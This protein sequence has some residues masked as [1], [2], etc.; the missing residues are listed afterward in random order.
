MYDVIVVGAGHAG[1][2]AA[3]AAAN[4][5]L[6]TLLATGNLNMTASMPCNPSIGGPAKGVVV[7]EIDALGGYMGKNADLCQIQTKM[8]NRSKGPAVWALRFQCD[9]LLYAREMLKH[10]KTV[11]NLDLVE[12][13]VEDVLVEDGSVKGITLDNGESIYSKAVILTTGTYLDSR[14]LRGH[15]TSKEG[16]DGQKT[17]KG[18]SN[19]LRR[20][21]FTIQRL[22]TGTPARIKASTID[23]S[24]VSVEN[25]DEITW[26][27]SHDKGYESL[28]GVKAPCYL[29]YT[30]QEIHDL[31]R[32]NLDK[33]AM[34]GGVVEGIGPRYCPSIEDKVVRFSDK[35]RHQIF[36]EPESLEIDQEYIQGF[37]TS[38]PVDVQDKMIRLLPGLKDCE[39]IRYAYA[40]EYDAIDPLE[41]WPSLE[42]KL[43]KN[44]FTAGQ[45]NGTS[46]YEEAAGQG[47][48]AG[49]NA[50]LK[51]QGKEPLILGR[52][53]AYIGLMIDDLV[54]K[55]TKEP[56]RLLTS[57]SEFRLLLRHD[58][59]DLRL[60]EK[61]YQVGLISEAQHERFLRKVKAIEDTKQFFLSHKI[62]QQIADPI[63]E[64][65]GSMPLTESTAL[66]SILKRPEVT[67]KHILEMLDKEGITLNIDYDSIDEVL[68][69]VEISFKYDGYIRKAYEMAARMKSYEAMTIPSD[70]NY[71]L[72]DNIALEAREK[73]KKVRPLTMGQASR[74]SGVNPADISVLFVY[75]EKL[76]R[77]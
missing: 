7:R 10:L 8:L 49:I 50:G 33:S 39:V 15:W 12:A 21:G 44:L 26:H 57:R 22:K 65:V 45:I 34:Y 46:G 4:M 43:V 9:K 35:E 3:M 68:E 67:Y 66:A 25:G 14:I 30:N 48:M 76:R 62:K 56:Y 51:V 55:G 5:G 31:I 72:V 60:R 38:M 58:N 20:M 11:K 13:I 23:F 28:T 41:L 24:K 37:S 73:L 36:Y 69:Q 63:L 54:T 29:A 71:D 52:D 42:T 1:C 47:L 27:Y 19:A 2:E 70:I 18:I 6:K 74:I 16:P 32:A 40:I 17:S 64:S 75:V 53:E 77:M 59:A 61:G